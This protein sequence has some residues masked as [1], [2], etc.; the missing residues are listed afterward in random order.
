MYVCMYAHVFIHVCVCVWWCWVYVCMYAHVFIHVC[1]CVC[2]CVC[3][4]IRINRLH[5]NIHTWLSSPRL[6]SERLVRAAAPVGRKQLASAGTCFGKFTKTRK[7][8]LNITALDYLAQY[9]TVSDGDAF[10]CVW[11][12]NNSDV[13]HIHTMTLCTHITLT[14][15]MYTCAYG[16]TFLHVYHH[17]SHHHLFFFLFFCSDHTSFSFSLFFL[18]F[19]LSCVV[20]QN[21]G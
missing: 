14:W 15:I 2:M 20:V 9:A 16:G 11:K 7:F 5:S 13:Y 12:N 8:R 19:F 3:V 4:C 18:S 17:H 1:V 21:L 6:P 10:I